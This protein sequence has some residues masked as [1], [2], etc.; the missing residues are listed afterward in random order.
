M[1]PT[2]STL[3]QNH[4]VRRTFWNEHRTNL[5]LPGATLRRPGLTADN[6]AE[7]NAAIGS[8]IRRPNARAQPKASFA[9]DS[10]IRTWTHYAAKAA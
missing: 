10:P 3:V 4:L 9:T 6:D 5:A 7:Q 8:F 2:I 1:Q